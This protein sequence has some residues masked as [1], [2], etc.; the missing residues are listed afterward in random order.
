MRGV[1]RT[2]DPDSQYT[3]VLRLSRRERETRERDLRPSS[4]RDESVRVADRWSLPLGETDQPSH[5]YG[6]ASAKRQ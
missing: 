3:R 5:S 4:P 2:P 6:S 1:R